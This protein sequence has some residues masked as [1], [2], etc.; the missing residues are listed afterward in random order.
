MEIIY[1]MALTR[2][3]GIGPVTARRLVAHCGSAE[4]VFKA[5][6]AELMDIEGV[7]AL[8]AQEISQEKY[9]SEAEKEFQYAQDQG[10]QMLLPNHPGYPRRL[11]HCE[12]APLVLFQKGP[13]QLNASRCLAIVGTRS[14]TTYGYDFLA[15]FTSDLKDYGV[16]IISGL[17]YG[18]DAAAHQ[19]ALDSG[20][21]T[22]AV[23][24]HGLDRVYPYLNRG[25]SER[26][27][28][29][30]GSLLSEFFSGSKPDRENFPKRNRIIAGM[31]DAVLVVEAG[32]KGGALITAEL[33]NSYHREVF[34]LPGPYHAPYSA[35]CN[36]LIKS[37]Q[38]SLLTGVKDLEYILG[39]TRM[40]AKA[41]EMQTTLFADLK[42]DE[43]A[44]YT[45]LEAANHAQTLD[46]LCHQLDWSVSKTLAVL[47]NLELKGLIRTLPGKRY[48][49]KP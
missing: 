42:G 27:L 44:L 9:C 22:V 36:H 25:L 11:K 29:Q 26:M 40:E 28:A 16:L 2:V 10:I 24:A 32:K 47:M 13:T 41:Q 18:I 6:P 43:G 3:H 4:A 23:M 12:D 19:E 33:A 5:P 30:G 49:K 31:S 38:A 48:Q 20:L 37:H 7:N 39:W 21:D 45:L 15:G 1:A 34:A 14:A 35:G 8:A 46:A 17:A